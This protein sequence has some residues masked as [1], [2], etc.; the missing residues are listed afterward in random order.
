MNFAAKSITNA[1]STLI[2]L[3][4]MASLANPAYAGA[5]SEFERH[6]Q[7]GKDFLSRQEYKLAV[8]ELTSALKLKTNSEA[9]VDRA[10]ALNE[11]KKY[12][13]ALKDLDQAL[14]I[15]PKSVMGLNIKG[16]VYL[17]TNRPDLAI[18][19]LD[20]A[21]S[22]DPADRYALVNRAGA[23]LLTTNPAALAG[24]TIACLEAQN[25]K[26]EFA[27]HAAV[28]T[29]LAYKASG[30]MQEAKGFSEKALKKLNRLYW[31]YPV[32]K[33][34]VGKESKDAA[35]EEAADST[36]NLTQAQTFLG[37]D[38]YFNH[39]SGECR[40]KL[41]FV[42]THGTVNSVEYWLAK[43]YLAKLKPEAQPNLKQP[44]TPK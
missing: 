25:W 10:T 36:Y 28:L 1:K 13:E 43:H 37:L 8:E 19:T 14:S 18:A 9:L 6:Y 5:A 42:T 44:K 38:A 31:P 15:N 27:G 33:Y 3:A 41:K 23:Y 20:K 32:L 11:M 26:N 35:V 29:V 12:E 24:R 21:L 17:R 7:V 4:I 22:I 30:Q 16:V 40:D 2:H 34:F 39:D